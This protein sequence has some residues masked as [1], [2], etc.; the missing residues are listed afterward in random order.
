MCLANK[1]ALEKANITLNT[2]EIPGGTIVRD[3]D[4]TKQTFSETYP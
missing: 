1:K 2:P 3:T 4:G